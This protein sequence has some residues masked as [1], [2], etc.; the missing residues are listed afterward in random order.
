ME[1]ARSVFVHDR[2]SSTIVCRV[3]EPSRAVP[4]RARVSVRESGEVSR[5]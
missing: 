5:L 3:S 4:R 1:S 2:V